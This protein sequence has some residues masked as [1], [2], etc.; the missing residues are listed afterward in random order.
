MYNV[1]M[2]FLFLEAMLTL[3][4]MAQCRLPEN[5]L[6]WGYET[7]RGGMQELNRLARDYSV[8]IMIDWSRFD[9][10]APFTIIYH[11]WCTYLPQ[12]IR[13]DR[14]WMPIDRYGS[15][16]HIRTFA[17]R[18]G[19][20]MKSNPKYSKFATSLIGKFAPHVLVFSFVVY[21][22]ISFLWMWF[23]RMVYVTP[24]GFGYQ[25]TLAGVC[26][27]LF[28]TQILDSFVNLFLFIDALLEFG[29]TEDEIRQIRLFIQGDDNIAYLDLDF[30]RVFD[31]YEW[32]PDYALKRWHMIV[33][34]DK[35]SITRRR[36]KIEVLGYR[37]LHGMPVRDVSKLV[38]TLA[39]PER[40]VT[41]PKWPII[42]MSRAIGIAYANAGHD[43]QVHKL[44]EAAYWRARKSSGLTEDELRNIPIEYK[45]LGMFEIFSV[46]I[47]E[48]D[49]LVVRDLSRFPDYYDIRANL[50]HWHGPHSVYPMWPSHFLDDL[51]SIQD[52][53]AVVTL[54][55]VM[56]SGGL[57]FE[58]HF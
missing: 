3:P 5:C 10:L 21:N 23:V 22:L 11:F 43:F 31:F 44:C 2:L 45:R 12:I 58:R 15:D 27:G 35:S 32:L 47:E 24:D 4:L 26:S 19:N 56:I 25:R 36:S 8:F 54:Y 55:D 18:H 53:D 51:S 16:M 34:V 9:Q 46:M 52:P 20:Y 57:Q 41:G 39:Y 17:S 29:F 28:M 30:Q 50:Y 1:P 6:L 33:S 49:E 14:G 38:A 48:I 7:I 40:Y 37:N 13:V 42:M